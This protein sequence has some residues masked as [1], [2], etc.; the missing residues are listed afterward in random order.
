MSFWRKHLDRPSPNFGERRGVQTPDMI[1]LHYTGMETAGAAIDRLCD[2][3]EEVSAHYLIDLDGARTKLVRPRHRAWHAGVSSW[4]GVHDVNS[5]SIGIELVNPGH[6]P[7]YCP[8]PEPQMS[9]L[10]ALLDYLINRFR[11]A[12]ERVVGHACIAPLRKQDPGPKFDWRRLALSGKA[13]WLDPERPAQPEAEPADAS[14]FQDAARRFGFLAPESGSWCTETR[15]IWRAFQ[16]RFL[17][18]CP[19]LAPCP[20]GIRHME[21]LSQEWPCNLTRDD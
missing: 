7:S 13:V 2:P 5:H 10:E 6:G 17:P 12:P 8:F 16:A 20:S 15:A 4:G 19:Q 21:R 9:Q 3:A 18:Q 1:V 11:I 14:R